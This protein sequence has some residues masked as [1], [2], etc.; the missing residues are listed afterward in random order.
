[1]TDAKHGG[2]SPLVEDIRLLKLAEL[3][4]EAY[5]RFVITM[6]TQVVEDPDVRARLMRLVDPAD[7]HGGRIH[8]QLERL[9]GMLGQKDATSILLGA[10]VDV[11]EVEMSARDF[12]LDHADDAHDPKVRELFH[13]LAK[14]EA[15]H[16]R[17]AQQTL[18]EA[19]K[20]AGLDVDRPVGFK[21]FQFGLVP[22]EEGGVGRFQMDPE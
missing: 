7:D 1:M 19:K 14:A 15:A 21:A 16:L 13:E 4:E 20:R 10:L 9:N 18:R 11:C 12:Y 2:I 6:A 8:D 3:Y 22:T 17:I 5:E